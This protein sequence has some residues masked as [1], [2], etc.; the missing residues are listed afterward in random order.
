M[1][2]RRAPVLLLALSLVAVVGAGVYA[3]QLSGARLALAQ[4]WLLSLADLA[5]APSTL[6]AIVAL[7]LSVGLGLWGLMLRR[8]LGSRGAELF[9]RLRWGARPSPLEDA[10]Q[11]RWEGELPASLGEAWLV[12]GRAHLLAGA[13]TALAALVVG[14]LQ[15][16]ATVL[17]VAKPAREA[18]VL[19]FAELQRLERRLAD[20]ILSLDVRSREAEL[21][22]AIS[23]TPSAGPLVVVLD[24]AAS[25]RG[26]WIGERIES[27]LTRLARGA[28]EVLE[29]R[30]AALVFMEP[31]APDRLLLPDAIGAPLL[32][33]LA[34]V[35]LW[36]GA[37]LYAPRE[38]QGGLARWLV[39]LGTGAAWTR[40]GERW[41]RA[42][43]ITAAAIALLALALAIVAPALL[44]RG[45][46][47]TILGTPDSSL[48]GSLWSNW[49]IARSITTGHLSGLQL[50]DMVFWPLGDQLIP[51]FGNLLAAALS[52]PFQWAFG[53]P[54]Y[55]TW[56]LAA[57]V[58][59]N[60]VA[61]AALARTAGASRLG[62][63]VAGLG[64]AACPP[65]LDAMA[66][67][68][69][70]VFWAAALPMALRAGLLALDG[71][72][73]R[74]GWLAGLWLGITALSS[75]F[76]AIFALLMLVPMGLH[77]L[78]TDPDDAR[79]ATRYHQIGRA[80]RASLPFALAAGPLIASATH[81]RMV[82]L[83]FAEPP[84]ML[85]GTPIGDM[86]LR[87]ISAHSIS[88]LALVTAEDPAGWLLVAL[89]LGVPLG[90]LLIWR[91]RRW[92][93]P[94]FALAAAVLSWGPTVQAGATQLTLPYAA[95]Y[96]WMPFF[97]RLRYPDRLLIVSALMIALVAGMLLDALRAR[98][99]SRTRLPL[100]GLALALAAAPAWLSGRAPLA[101]FSFDPPEIYSL[102]SGDGALVEL[103][104]G[105]RES[106]ILYQPLHGH[107]LV[108]GPGEYLESQSR[109]VL[110]DVLWA[111]PVLRGLGEREVTA[112]SAEDLATIHA[113]GLRYILVNDRVLGQ[114]LSA[115]NPLGNDAVFIANRVD[116]TFGPP[117][118]QSPQAR[119]YRVP[120]AITDDQRQLPR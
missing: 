108:N 30:G 19:R 26:W 28:R 20:R 68:Q 15:R 73:A 31:L 32:A 47:V 93:W 111:N 13:P 64:F 24:G 35:R 103:P 40:R 9:L 12:P 95:L 116:A 89:G 18:D 69:Q 6:L 71:E 80:V 54:G 66:D 65:L 4:A 120:A 43:G 90:W 37:R 104:I 101:T 61:A 67:A 79:R 2:R 33:E 70:Q 14:L 113:R 102:L 105:F 78:I 114:L 85:G 97:S 87:V 99:P 74:D 23:R 55:W 100:A 21:L 110:R 82:G 46:G 39:D 63:L 76:Y 3:S 53:Y 60:G 11:P 25:L 86:L 10:P 92:G 75:W 94:A 115:G 34:A 119:L 29:A 72:R 50:S 58:F 91:G 49:W 45:E 17:L 41:L 106:A 84:S 56:L 112:F 51:R 5:T 118:Y 36:D 57:A 27:R 38:G 109:G 44:A 22:R 1:I 52:T 59:V 83:S 8:E 98:V 88:P 96:A 77:R 16:G 62:A 7:A 48:P 117:I 107:A 42:F 81:G